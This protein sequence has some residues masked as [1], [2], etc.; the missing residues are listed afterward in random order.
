MTPRSQDQRRRARRRAD[1]R[2]RRR[3]RGARAAAGGR[4]TV[5]AAVVHGAPANT[6]DWH[7]RRHRRRASTW[8]RWSP[9]RRL[10]LAAHR[11]RGGPL[12]RGGRRLTGARHRVRRLAA[13]PEFRPADGGPAAY[14]CP[15]WRA[16]RRRGGPCASSRRSPCATSDPRRPH[17]GGAGGLRA[18][19]AQAS[20]ARGDTRAGVAPSRPHRDRRPAWPAT[21]MSRAPSPRARRGRR[22]GAAASCAGGGDRRPVSPGHRDRIHDGAPIDLARKRPG[23]SDRADAVERIEQRP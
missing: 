5:R 16:C 2:A 18:A 10:S 8:C 15:C 20:R 7:S 17:S 19:E 13:G 4:R 3:H 11:L 9:A 22:V 6:G 23:R 14:R 12:D 1:G 21:T